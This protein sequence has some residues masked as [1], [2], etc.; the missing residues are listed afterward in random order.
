M[1]IRLLRGMAALPI[2]KQE[3]GTD[4]E[5]LHSLA[6]IEPLGIECNDVLCLADNP[7]TQLLRLQYLYL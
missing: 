2:T 1:G 4:S 5:L 6:D 3:G 7:L